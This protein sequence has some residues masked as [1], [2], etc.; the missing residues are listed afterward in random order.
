M[1]A[2]ADDVLALLHELRDATRGRNL[3]GRDG[4]LEEHRHAGHGVQQAHLDVAAGLIRPA[5]RRRAADNDAAR[6][7]RARRRGD[8]VVD[9]AVHL[10]LLVRDRDLRAEL[11]VE[12]RLAARRVRV[13]ERDDAQPS[14]DL[15]LEARGQVPRALVAAEHDLRGQSDR[16]TE[17]ARCR[18]R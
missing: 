18:R 1:V 8:E 11:G 3:V 7:L 16:G 5:E 9:V 2:D 12:L 14:A 13:D 6:P 17:G 4:L 10:G 15:E